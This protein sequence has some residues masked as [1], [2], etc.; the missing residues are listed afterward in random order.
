M[1]QKSI[2]AVLAF[3]VGGFGVHKFYLGNNFAGILY[4][5]FFWTFIPSIL[6]IFDFLGLLLMSEQAFNAKYNLQEVN[7]LNLLQS[8]E[9]D[10][11]DKLKKIKELYDQ[12]IITAEEYEEKRR[13]FLDLL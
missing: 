7:K 1:K 9:N 10:N 13:K 6:A 8:S 2:A 11:I 4:L 3:F 12:G 5:L